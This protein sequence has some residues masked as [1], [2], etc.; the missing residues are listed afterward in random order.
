MEQQDIRRRD[1]ELTE[2]IREVHHRL[3]NLDGPHMP[4]RANSSTNRKFQEL[5]F[6]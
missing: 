5:K 3:G 2:F 4:P 1:L 6:K